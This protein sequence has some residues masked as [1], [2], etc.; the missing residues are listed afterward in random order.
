MLLDELADLETT[1]IVNEQ[2]MLL[3]QRVCVNDSRIKFALNDYAMMEE[4]SDDVKERMEAIWGGLRDKY[5]LVYVENHSEGSIGKKT[6]TKK[7]ETDSLAKEK[8]PINQSS[9]FRH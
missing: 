7:A 4:T 1:S 6:I 3:A 2:Q 9:K 5:S 8:E